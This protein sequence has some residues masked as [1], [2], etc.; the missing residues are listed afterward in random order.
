LDTDCDP[1]PVDVP[2]PCNDDSEQT[3]RL[4]LNSLAEGIANGQGRGGVFASQPQQVQVTEAG[5][6]FGG[7]EAPAPSAPAPAEET[8]T[9]D[10]VAPDRAPAPDQDTR[11][12][13]PV[14][15]DEAPPSG[16]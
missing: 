2:I 11:S 7:E 6:S 3:I 5:A 13:S 9:P 14:V 1:D 4:V 15:G 16:N 8:K 12:D 10:D